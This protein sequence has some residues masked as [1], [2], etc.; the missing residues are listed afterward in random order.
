M[1]KF[2]LI[3]ATSIMAVSI[4]ACSKASDQPEGATPEVI[5]S[6]ENSETTENGETSSEQTP[7]ENAGDTTLA[8][9]VVKDGVLQDG[10]DCRES[11]FEWDAVDGADGYEISVKSK[12]YAD[13]EF[14][15]PEEI[16]ETTDTFYALGAQD[17]FDF[18]IK[19]RAYKGEGADRV[20]SDWSE[21][22]AGFTYEDSD[23]AE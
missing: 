21:E 17:A 23:I 6:V 15:E 12:Y 19:V 14:T 22:A 8:V 18:I 16:Y 5:D 10:E 13:A 4:M 3:L 20:Y 9:P 7:S 2:H 1:K 11:Y